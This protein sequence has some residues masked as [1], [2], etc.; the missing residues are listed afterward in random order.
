MYSQE[1]FWFGKKSLEHSR[2]DLVRKPPKPLCMAHIAGI[3][4]EAIMCGI[5]PIEPR[6]THMYPNISFVV[7]EEG[8]ER[9][10]I[11]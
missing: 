2:N 1:T 9:L 8:N 4:R 5:Q 7:Y 3:E 10:L 11:C 6:K